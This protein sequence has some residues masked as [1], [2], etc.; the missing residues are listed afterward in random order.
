[1]VKCYVVATGCVFGIITGAHVLRV[2]AEGTHLLRAPLFMFLTALAAAMC[3]WAVVVFR[4]I[5]KA[6]A[7]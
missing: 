5:G 6:N 4:R 7:P 1:M 2:V 3:V